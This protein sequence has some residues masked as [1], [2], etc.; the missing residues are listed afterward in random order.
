MAA[1]L[2]EMRGQ[3]QDLPPVLWD[4]PIST[5]LASIRALTEPS[6]HG[7]AAERG[8][9]GQRSGSTGRKPR[10][11]GSQ[12]ATGGSAH[13]YHGC[14]RRRTSCQRISSR[15]LGTIHWSSPVPADTP[16]PRAWCRQL[17]PKPPMQSTR[18]SHRSQRG[19]QP[20]PRHR[21]APP[22]VLYRLALDAGSAEAWRMP[23]APAH[24]DGQRARH[25][26]YTNHDRSCGTPTD[27]R[28]RE[29]LASGPAPLGRVA[30]AELVG[31]SCRN[32][33]RS[34]PGRPNNWA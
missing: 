34:S 12:P 1:L 18:S 31:P 27:G 9:S 29:W 17:Y 2:A 13:Q 11:S 16:A 24:E 15:A 30:M 32:P 14:A 28:A 6:P 21:Q 33:R 8:C 7:R 5:P 20:T 25:D 26:R 19:R 4:T 10:T 23:S 3:P 22:S